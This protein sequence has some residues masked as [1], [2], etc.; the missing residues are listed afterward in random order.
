MSTSTVSLHDGLQLLIP[1]GSVIHINLY[2][3]GIRSGVTIPKKISTGELDGALLGIQ[4][5][6]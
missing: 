4:L 6:I 1:T 2:F 3:N 5:N